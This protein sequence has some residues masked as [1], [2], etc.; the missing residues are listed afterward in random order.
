MAADSTPESVDTNADGGVDLTPATNA[1]EDQREA[2][3]DA[4]EEGRSSFDR[5]VSSDVAADSTPESVDT[6]ADGVIDLTPATNA[7][8]DQ[9]EA[10]DNAIE[11]GRSSFGRPVSSDR[12]REAAAASD[13]PETSGLVAGDGQAPAGVSN[14][15]IVD[16]DPRATRGNRTVAADGIEDIVVP[17]VPN[18][19]GADPAADSVVAPV[20]GQSFFHRMAR[21]QTVLPYRDTEADAPAPVEATPPALESPDAPEPSETSTVPEPATGK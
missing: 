15:V 19:T 6:N 2:L 16:A 9:R 20:A 10:L 13:T 5:P 4:I 18:A 7:A 11:E 21:E 1:A 14:E 3:D 17:V 8:E 12:A